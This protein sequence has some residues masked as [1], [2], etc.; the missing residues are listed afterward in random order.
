VNAPESKTFKGTATRSWQGTVFGFGLCG[1]SLVTA[2]V[3]LLAGGPLPLV[4]AGT[5]IFAIF[6]RPAV[7]SLISALSY[8]KLLIDN[9]GMTMSAPGHQRRI[10]WQHVSEV[11]LI[12][13]PGLSNHGWLVVRP[14]EG[15]A[16]PAPRPH[17]PEWR[18]DLSAIKF[19]DLDLLGAARFEALEA[20]KKSAGA[21]WKD[22]PDHNQRQH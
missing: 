13:M 7:S 10:L 9:Q 15:I 22:S 12:P 2:V 20:I 17:F 3:A 5:L 6:I 8:P 16:K 19:C 14:K 11:A 4:L 21:L 1:A 18:P